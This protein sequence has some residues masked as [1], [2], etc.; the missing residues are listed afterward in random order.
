MSQDTSPH[1]SHALPYTPVI[2]GNASPARPTR[3]SATKSITSRLGSTPNSPTPNCQPNVQASN[4]ERYYSSAP[5]LNQQRIQM[6]SQNSK[7]NLN[8]DFV[9]PEF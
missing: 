3:T 9:Q 8:P 2:N 1:K 4:V 5:N 6:R 7:P